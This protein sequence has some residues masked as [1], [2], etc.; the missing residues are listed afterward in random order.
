MCGRRRFPTE[1]EA[2]TV[3]IGRARHVGPLRVYACPGC[4]GWHLTKRAEPPAEA[5]A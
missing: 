3:A 1:A 4:G 2:V 5:V